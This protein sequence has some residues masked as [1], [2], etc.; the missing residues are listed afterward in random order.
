MELRGRLPGAT[1]LATGAP[2]S[3][4]RKLK[5]VSSLLSR[6]P[7]TMMRLPKNDSIVVVIETALPSRVDDR[8]VASCP[9]PRPPDRRRRRPSRPRACPASR[10]AHRFL[11]RDQRRA[12][13]EVARDR[14]APSPA[15]RRSDRRP[16]SGRDRR[17]RGA[18][19]PTTRCTAC[20]GVRAHARHVEALEH[21]QDL[22]HRDAARG[23]GRH[24]AKLPRAIVAAQA[25]RR[26][27]RDSWRGPRRVSVPGLRWPRTAATM[28]RAIS[29]V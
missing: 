22:Q 23:R 20:G 9:R 24:A 27:A 26:R 11:G 14:A 19:P 7:R 18:R 6:K 29:P 12:L 16:R 8:D 21:A 2:S 15:R 28:S 17:R 25:A 10:L 3:T 4:G 5:S 13:G 1:L